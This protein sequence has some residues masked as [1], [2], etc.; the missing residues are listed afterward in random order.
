M[1]HKGL[2]LIDVDGPLNPFA[3]QPHR[4]PPGFETFRYTSGGGWLSGRQARKRKGMRVWL[5]PTHGSA[6]LDLA[7]DTGLQ[8]VWCTTWQ[9]EANTHIGPAVGL[10]QLPVI[11]F[12]E[13][14]LLS[15]GTG[16]QSWRRDGNW[17]WA[18]VARYAAGRPLAWLD[19]DHDD[20][21]FGAARADFDKQ[22]LATPT[23]LSH[24]DPR[25]GIQSDHLDRI[26]AWTSALSTPARSS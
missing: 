7:A 6:L 1:N 12:P 24:V 20:P 15:Y 11:E 17:K 3:A 2:L 23:L 19:D 25:T 18:A 5:N 22:R 10:P 21:A 4:R 26:R 9:H 14:D 8:L 16:V 13:E